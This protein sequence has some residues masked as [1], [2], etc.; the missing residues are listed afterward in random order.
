[1]RLTAASC[2]AAL[3]LCAAG[4]RA[5]E[6]L[7]VYAAGDIAQCG[8]AGAGL[9]A[10][11]VAEADA[12]VL[13]VGD[14]AYPSGRTEDFENCYQPTWG[15][16]KARTLPV[17]GNHEYRTQG[18]AGYFGYFGARAMPFRGGYY[19]TD[20]GGWHVVALNSNLDLAPGSAQIE[21]L[22]E[23]LKHNR[24]GCIL[25]FW[26]HPR[27][28]SGQHGDNAAMQPLWETLQRNGVSVALS[29]HDHNYER[30]APLDA[31]GRPD[32]RRGLR[33]FVVG[34]GGARL[35]EMGKTRPHSE[36]RDATDWGILR[37]E[38]YAGR[39][40]W[41]YLTAGGKVTDQGGGVCVGQ[42]AR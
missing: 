39:Y 15:R 38:L 8:V 12:Q 3:A 42:E 28:S 4:A 32:A 41:K 16:F 40:N 26:H 18:A 20:L 23:D 35:Y 10:R 2:I 33:S 7:V 5:A 31:E 25:A 14:L 11:L 36:M 9:T 21:W 30:L 37:L 27:F 17:P 22:V 13:A 34:A 19:S 24:R 1:M 29:G 6:P